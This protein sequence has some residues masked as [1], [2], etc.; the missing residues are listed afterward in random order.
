MP[1]EPAIVLTVWESV[2]DVIARTGGLTFWP[3]GVDIEEADTGAEQQ[4][5]ERA[6]QAQ[7][8]GLRAQPRTCERG[9]TIAETILSVADDI[10]ANAIV[11]GTR[12]LTGDSSRSC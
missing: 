10:D 11:L 8:A 12:G 9:T 7:R 6:E 5:R 2:I 1:N 3:D 4:A